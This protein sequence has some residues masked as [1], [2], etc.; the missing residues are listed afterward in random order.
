MKTQEQSLELRLRRG[1]RRGCKVRAATKILLEK[2][3]A[4]GVGMLHE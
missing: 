1:L 4:G 2:S 3:L